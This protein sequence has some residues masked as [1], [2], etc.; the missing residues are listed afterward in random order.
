MLLLSLES[1]LPKIKTA[2]S[3]LWIIHS[4]HIQIMMRM[5]PHGPEKLSLKVGPPWVDRVYNI[6]DCTSFLPFELHKFTKVRGGPPLKTFGLMKSERWA[7][8]WVDAE[9]KNIKF[10]KF[11]WQKNWYTLL[12]YILYQPKGGPPLGT[13]SL[14]HAVCCMNNGE[15]EK[16]ENSWWC[17]ALEKPRHI[18]L[19]CLIL[20]KRKTSCVCQFCE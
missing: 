19:L 1:K 8:L 15:R 14:A 5:I 17:W 12:Y 4:S 20:H 10:M 16:G 2:G 11:K 7:P 18:F 6:K 9:S 3:I 13:T